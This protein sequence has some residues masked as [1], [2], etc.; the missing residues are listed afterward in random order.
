[1]KLM[2]WMKAALVAAVFIVASNV[3]AD[4]IDNEAIEAA[5]VAP[6]GVLVKVNPATKTIEVFR[7]NHLDNSIT[8]KTAINSEM[9]S[10]I[11]EIEKPAN[12][13]AEFKMSNQELD[14][15]TSTQAWYYSWWGAS[16][17]WN[18]WGGYN[19]Y[20]YNWYN[21]YRNAGYFNYNYSYNYRYNYSYSYNNCNYGWYY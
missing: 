14:K 3:V 15:D 10:S 7:A 4:Q 17:R 20:N 1:M 16:W 21:P 19:N 5:K 11:N 13:I 18:S 8:S 2:T 6:R 9:N 12:K